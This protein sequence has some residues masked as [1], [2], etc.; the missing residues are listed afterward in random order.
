MHLMEVKPYN[1]VNMELVRLIHIS[2]A[3]NDTD[4]FWLCFVF[5]KDYTY[6]VE[7]DTEQ[8]AQDFYNTYLVDDSISA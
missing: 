6:Y 3:Q 7:F 5:E 2:P 4:K 8:Q 1:M